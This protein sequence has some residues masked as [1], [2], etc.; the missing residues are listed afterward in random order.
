MS[1]HLK[2]SLRRPVERQLW[3]QNFAQGSKS[4]IW[5][6]GR[7]DYSPGTGHLSGLYVMSEELHSQNIFLKVAHTTEENWA[8]QLPKTIFPYVLKYNFSR[9]SSL[10]LAS[11]AFTEHTDKCEGGF[12]NTGLKFPLFL[13]KKLV[14]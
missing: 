1:T 10:L 4:N 9:A 5:P 13:T 2:S 11:S 7:A 14:S 3:K 6:E 12:K 8:L